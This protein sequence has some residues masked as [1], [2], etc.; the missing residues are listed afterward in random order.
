MVRRWS[1][2]RLVERGWALVAAIALSLAL[3]SNSA[4]FA[5]SIG[6]ESIASL[7]LTNFAVEG[8][9]S[10]Q[11]APGRPNDL[12]VGILDGRILRV[13][14][15]N[16]AV[17]TF[18][19]IPDIDQ[20]GA[21]GFFGLHG[22][23]FSPNFDTNGQL[24]V[25]VADERDVEVGVHHRNY[26]RRYDIASPMSNAPVLGTATDIIRIDQPRNDH[27]GG[28]LGF[29]PG[30]ANTLWITNGDG[31]NNDG[32]PDPSRTGQNTQDLIGSILRVDLSGDDF[33]EDPTRNYKIP[34]NN[35]FADGVA[36]R[37]E[38]W[39]Y[40]VRSPWGASFDRTNGDF[41]FG[42]VGQVTREEVNF[43]RAGSAGG[44]NYGWRVMEGAEP[45]VF[46]Q[47]PGD[48]PPNDPSFIAPVL[49]YAHTGNYGGG[50]S[51]SFTGRS[52][53]GGYIYRG[54]IAELQGK[55]IYGDWSSR[56]V[57]AVTIDRD[58]NG[59]LGGIVP[60]SRFN[61]ATT[62]N[63][64]AVYG[65]A[66]GF[67]DGITA[68]GEDV[69][70]NLYYS[71]LDG[72]IYK[73]CGTCGPGLPEP[74]PEPAPPRGPMEPLATLRDDFTASFNYQTGNVPAAGIWTDSHNNAFGDLF[75]ANTTNAGQLT[76]AHERVGWEGNGADTAPFLFR[77]VNAENLLEVR[78][79]I[80]AQT[81]TS[82]S[83]AGL[84]V[85]AA[86]ALDDD[87]ANDN[88]IS[89]HSFRIGTAGNPTN[90]LQISNVIGGA[91]GETNVGLSEADLMFLRMVNHGNGN[92]E[93]FTSTNGTAWTSRGE[94][95]SEALASGMLEVG[96]W[97]GNYGGGTTG[98]TQFDWAEI[99]TGVPAGDFNE[100]GI[101]DAADYTVWRDTLGQ[102]VTKWAGADGDGDGLVT[103][104]DYSVWKQNYGLEIP[105][106]AGSLAS[107]PE[108]SCVWLVACGLVLATANCR[109]HARPRS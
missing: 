14:L 17:S 61:L 48:L 56:Q 107:V 57:W 78:L 45:S 15:T 73:M 80:T 30:D 1:G 85:R 79:K 12:F 38:I 52:V 92:F 55:Y 32:D 74:E 44:R 59:G 91:E 81:R 72:S 83:S 71:E 19:T 49:D 27:N 99:I 2:C 101:I 33:P 65:G 23:T 67:G 60:G 16:N 26:V 98:S 25:H 42:D 36:G 29:Q 69:A 18:A 103:L 28:F 41:V 31:G 35:P 43:E 108:P 90:L 10:I 50:D 86:G 54:P 95:V 8:V 109:R 40:G 34:A 87:A 46:P 13:D 63:R 22:F 64:T 106:G 11:S 5:Q 47:E 76:I 77:E 4:V 66:G 94:V 96:L 62:L 53:T 82:W 84:L 100:D 89:A 6:A 88:F 21:S 51:Q 58:A 104:S 68:F 97:A 9:T 3:G 102:T 105:D 20:T 75:N 24:F 93:I 7:N 37:P 39:S 70:G